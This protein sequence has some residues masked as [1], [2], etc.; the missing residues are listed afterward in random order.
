MS[1][2]AVRGPT[3]GAATRPLR[4]RVMRRGL[5]G[6]ALALLA[7]LII[8][9]EQGDAGSPP[10]AAN[11]PATWADLDATQPV[12]VSWSA[13]LVGASLTW[14][15]ERPE[16]V[17]FCVRAAVRLTEDGGASWREL[18]TTGVVAA[19]AAGYPLLDTGEGTPPCASLALDPTEAGVVYAVFRAGKEGVGAPPIVFVGFVSRDGGASWQLIP[20]V[21]GVRDEDFGGV[22]V[23]GSHVE[24]WYR[25]NVGVVVGRSDDGGRTWRAA[26]PSC[27]TA[28]P[29]VRFGPA[30]NLIGSCNMAARIQPLV[31]AVAV[32]GTRTPAPLASGPPGSGVNGCL[33]SE[34]V[35]LAD[36]EVIVLTEDP[37][38]LTASPLRWSG[39]GGQTWSPVALPPL[40]TGETP[41][42]RGLRLLP[43]GSLIVRDPLR[44]GWLLLPPRAGAWC[45]AGTERTPTPADT[46]TVRVIGDGLWW[47]ATASDGEGLTVARLLPLADLRCP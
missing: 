15:V 26:P 4:R 27:P 43:D 21:P 20:H 22:V 46:S 39:D 35:A 6:S 30:P 32:E 33:T 7:L 17:A 23:V 16:R 12:Y 2:G 40:P 37:L 3:T 31:H 18:P 34:L 13:N 28:G 9:C 1:I 45:G 41:L 44:G 10:A 19:A 24:A 38:D 47:L 11:P 42:W 14:D 5:W 8:G 36:G 29:C 25:A